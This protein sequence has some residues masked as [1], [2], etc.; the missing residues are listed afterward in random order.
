MAKVNEF[1]SPA[2]NIIANGTTVKGDI[3]CDGDFRI[4]GVLIGSITSKA[5]I[6]I[7]NTGT[8]EGDIKCQNGDFSGIIKANVVVAETLTLKSSARLIGNINIGKLSIEPGSQFS[9]N[10]RMENADYIAAQD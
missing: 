9:G 7:G 2:I 8:I 1:E 5:K 6:I 4:D 10:C 3:I